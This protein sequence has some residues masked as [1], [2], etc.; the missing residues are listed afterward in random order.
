MK[1]YFCLLLMF[2]AMALLSTPPTFCQSVSQGTIAAGKLR[3]AVVVS[4]SH[5][6]PIRDL[7]SDDFVIE[8]AGKPL[9]GQVQSPVAAAQPA[10]QMMGAA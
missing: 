6:A 3:F 8:V 2:P 7:H 9:P 5:G 1:R 4:D 10:A